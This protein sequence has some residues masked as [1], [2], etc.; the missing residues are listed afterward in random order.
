MLM[1]SIP[2]APPLEQTFRHAASKLLQLYG[3]HKA[4]AEAKRKELRR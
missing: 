4:L 3:V 1:P 2:G